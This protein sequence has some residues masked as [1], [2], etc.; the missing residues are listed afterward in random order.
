MG[1]DQVLTYVLVGFFFALGA[2]LIL[3]GLLGKDNGGE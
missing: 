2:I 1:D 3:A